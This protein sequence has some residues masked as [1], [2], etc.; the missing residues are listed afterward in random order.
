MELDCLPLFWASQ[1]AQWLKNPPAT[2]EMQETSVR[3][4]GQKIPW[5]RE[6]QPTPGIL[7]WGIPWTEEP[8]GLQSIELKDSDIAKSQTRL[9][10]LS[11][12]THTP[13]FYY[14][15]AVT[16]ISFFDSVSPSVEWG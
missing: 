10:Q 16:Y 9:K 4:L 15:L 13:L 8:G 1:V 14:L 6:W 3:S 5:R 2:Q 7:A 11:M 12:H